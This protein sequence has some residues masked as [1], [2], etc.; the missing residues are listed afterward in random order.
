MVEKSFKNLDTCP[1]CK[2]KSYFLKCGICIN[3]V[4]ELHLNKK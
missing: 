2:E 1:F 4:A 3:C